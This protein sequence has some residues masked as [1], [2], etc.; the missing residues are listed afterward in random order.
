MRLALAAAMF[1]VAAT[2]DP[3]PETKAPDLDGTWTVV[4]VEQ[5]RAEADKQVKVDKTSPD[6]LKAAD[7]KVVFKG[8]EMTVKSKG[9]NVTTAKITLDAD[10]SPDKKV[11]TID[12]RDN[13]G[14]TELG[15]FEL[16]GDDL[17]LCLGFSGAERPKSLA[18]GQKDTRFIVLRREK[19]EK[20][21]EKD[22]KD[23]DTP[24]DKD[25]Q[26]DK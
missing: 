17:T 15:L 3:K 13:K 7:L 1:S 20:P 9:N 11:R 10:R 18:P 22:T 2:D 8:D 26:K 14:H 16:K 6:A 5:A 25:A 24:K 21:P 4:S 19:E 12:T 23:K